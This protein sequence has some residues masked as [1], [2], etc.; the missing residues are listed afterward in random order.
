MRPAG[1]RRRPGRRRRAARPAHRGRGGGAGRRR[2]ASRPTRSAPRSCCGPPASGRT[3]LGP[4]PHRAPADLRR[5][6]GARRRRPAAGGR[7]PARSTRSAPSSPSRSTRSGTRTPRSCC[8]ARSAP[9]PL[10]PGSPHRDN[11]AGYVGMGW[12]IRKWPRPEDRLTFEDDEPD[13]NGLPGHPDRLRA[14]RRARRPSSSGP[15]VTRRAPPRRWVSSSTACRWSCRPAA[16]CT[17]WAPSGWGRSTTA[18]ASATRTR[19]C[20]ACPGSCWPATG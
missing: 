5:G 7:R 11:P 18:R 10:P 14:D 17:T 16:R 15:A 3:A 2:G 9:A 6:R 8:T 19:G 13:E 4:L 1:P 20:G 12:G